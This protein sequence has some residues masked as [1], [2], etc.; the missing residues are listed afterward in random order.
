MSE[1]PTTEPTEPTAT[2]QAAATESTA[3]D[4]APAAA[5]TAATGP[6]NVDGCRRDATNRG[7]CDAHWATHR[8]F[9]TPRE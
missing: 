5:A 4:Q 8:G 1:D 2:D 7:L 9:A 6:C 3:T